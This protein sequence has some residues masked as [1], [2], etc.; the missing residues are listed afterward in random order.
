M[1][2][3]EID[4]KGRRKGREGREGGRIDAVTTLP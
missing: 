3:G 1:K 2:E 4:K